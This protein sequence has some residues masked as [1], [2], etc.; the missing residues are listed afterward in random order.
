VFFRC[1]IPG[2]PWLGESVH[3][4]SCRCA[5]RRRRRQEQRQVTGLAGLT[6]QPTIDMLQ[7]G[8]CSWWISYGKVQWQGDQVVGDNLYTYVDESAT[9]LVGGCEGQHSRPGWHRQI[10][11]PAIRSTDPTP[12][13]ESKTDGLKGKIE[14]E[15]ERRRSGKREPPLCCLSRDPAARAPYWRAVD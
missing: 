7:P 6:N 15:E 13:R 1:C 11:M 8:E 9:E 3:G 4:A 10:D 14:E 12:M 5:P 2:R